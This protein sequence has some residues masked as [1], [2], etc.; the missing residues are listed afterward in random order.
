MN[1]I[2]AIL[3]GVIVVLMLVS[4][5]L[6]VVDQRQFAVVYALGEIKEVITEPGLKF[7]LPP[8]FQNVVMLDNRVQTWVFARGR[9]AALV[10]LK[11]PLANREAVSFDDLL[12]YDLI[13]LHAGA[14]AQELMREQAAARGKTLN[15]REALYRKVLAS[16][17]HMATS[18]GVT[19]AMAMPS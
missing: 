3:A 18:A 16:Y 1:R 8:P 15:A 7:K 12:A 6:F 19:Q 4:S 17:V 11:H 14:S 5:M 13:G 9:L 2:A 10:P